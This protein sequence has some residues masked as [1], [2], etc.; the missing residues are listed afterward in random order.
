MRACDVCAVLGDSWKLAILA[1]AHA[2]DDE[3]LTLSR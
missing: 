2:K 3:K 1:P